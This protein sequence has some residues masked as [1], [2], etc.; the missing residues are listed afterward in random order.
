[1]NLKTNTNMPIKT[2]EFNY[3]FYSAAA[4]LKVDTEKFTPEKAKDTLTFFVWDYDK[5]ADP[6]EEVMKKYA[7][8]AIRLATMNSINT[9]GVISEFENYEGYYPVDGSHGITLINVDGYEFEEE[10]LEVEI[11]ETA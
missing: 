10:D 8:S 6:V 1:M 7:M 2:F 9:S 4:T 5:N 3:D 11:K